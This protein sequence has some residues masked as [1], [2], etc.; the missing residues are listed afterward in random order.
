[1]K[2]KLKTKLSMT[3]AFVALLTVFLISFFSNI[4]INR[5]FK[6]YKINQV[7]KNTQEIVNSLSLQ[8]SQ[9]T[10]TWDADFVHTIGMLALSDGFIVKLEDIYGNIVWDAETCDMT[11]CLQLVSRMTLEMDERSPGLDGKFVA[12]KLE[13]SLNQNKIG[14]ATIKSFSPYYLSENDISFINGLNSILIVI[15]AISLLISILVGVWFARRLS[16]PILKTVAVTKQIVGGNYS[17]RI[18]DKTDTAEIF[19]LMDSVNHLAQSLDKQET[20]RKQLTAD[21]AHELRTPLTTLQTH[22]EAI[23]EGV[24]EPTPERLQSCHD[25]VIRISRMI[26]DLDNL[27]KV[28]SGNMTLNLEKVNLYDITKS[29]ILGFENEIVKKFLDVSIEG[30]HSDIFADK[31]RIRQVLVNL[32]SNAIKYTPDRGKITVKLSETDENIRLSIKDTGIG[33]SESDLPYIF[34]RFYRADK[35]RNRMTGGSGIGLAIVKSI[36]TA[37]GGKVSANSML[38]EGSEFILEFPK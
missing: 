5:Q 31:D 28:E 34:E 20:I 24:W 27:A 25:E 22:I 14:V 30:K 16:N 38:N 37:H 4:F 1:M 10:K 33:I 17:T 11:S 6:D 8:Y 26:S 2:L 12:R 21:V 15:G 13:V 36:V 3:I 35:S 23:L 19:E 7:E 29:T 9:N 18:N 32:I